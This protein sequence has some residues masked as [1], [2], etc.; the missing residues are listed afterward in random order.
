MR[1]L[2]TNNTL[3]NKEVQRGQYDDLVRETA[4][5]LRKLEPSIP[6]DLLVSEIGFVLNAHHGLRLVET[7]DAFVSVEEHTDLATDVDLAVLYGKR[8]YAICPERFFV[9]LPM[10]PEGLLAMR[11][12][13]KEGV[14][15]NFTLGFSARQNYLAARLGDPTYVNVFLG[16]LNSFV[17][18]S[19]LGTGNG[20]GEKATAASQEA[21][22]ELRTRGTAHTRQIAASMRNGEQVWTLAGVDVMTMPLAVAEGYA[23]SAQP[24]V[25][26]RGPASADFVPEVDAKALRSLHFET[27][28]DVPQSFRTTVEG[29][30]KKDLDR[31]SGVDLATYMR[32]NGAADIFP[33]YSATDIDTIRKDGKIPNLERW[34]ARLES[35]AVG[36]DS[37][38]NVSALQSFATDQKA[39]DD[40]IRGL[41]G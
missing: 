26:G 32:Q 28:W 8:F 18:E 1:A 25:A 29:L 4:A 34:R 33:E 40:R 12:L 7:F 35:G 41:L 15:I 3:L 6:E 37:L 36:L 2:T 13:R 39:L 21:L 14:P 30:V 24:P 10:T 9:K 38:F 11:R 19:K 16:R 23:K 17:A 31:M 27:L 20:V 22:T 5:H